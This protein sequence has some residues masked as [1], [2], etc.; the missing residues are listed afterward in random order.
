MPCGPKQRFLFLKAPWGSVWFH[1][2][3]LEEVHV[4]GDVV[5]RI[6]VARARDGGSTKTLGNTI[7]HHFKSSSSLVSL[8][9]SKRQFELNGVANLFEVIDR[10]S[11][12]PERAWVFEVAQEIDGC[13]FKS[14][15]DVG[16]LG[17][18]SLPGKQLEG[19]RFEFD[20][21]P[22]SEQLL[23]PQA[24]RDCVGGAREMDD[25]VFA[26]SNVVAQSS[27]RANAPC[28]ARAF[29]S[30]RVDGSRQ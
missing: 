13:R 16:W 9:T 1:K 11:N 7:Q 24:P 8:L 15:T 12:E 22:M 27:F 25:D 19:R 6:E 4:G 26:P 5:G 18:A 10:E 14:L 2:L 30:A 17:E 3:A 23:A 29:N 28:S 21:D 20:P